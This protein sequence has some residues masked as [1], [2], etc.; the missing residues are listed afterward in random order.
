MGGQAG[1]CKGIA[2]LP[3]GKGQAGGCKGST[4]SPPATCPWHS[5]TIRKAGA[6]SVPI[7]RK[8]TV[9]APAAPWQRSGSQGGSQNLAVRNTFVGKSSGKVSQR[10]AAPLLGLRAGKASGK[11]AKGVGSASLSPGAAAL[12]AKLKAAKGA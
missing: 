1:G 10:P 7:I 4:S 12:A 9:Q 6:L 8:A 2:K 11:S 3:G 5:G